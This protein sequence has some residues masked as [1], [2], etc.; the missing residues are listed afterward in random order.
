M[1]LEKLKSEKF[2]ALDNDLMGKIRGGQNVGTNAGAFMNGG[3]PDISTHDINVYND[4]GV[5]LTQI[6]YATDGSKHV[7]SV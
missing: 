2:R 5:L 7:I 6:F 4:R 3:V 1:K